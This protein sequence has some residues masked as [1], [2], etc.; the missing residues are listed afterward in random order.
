MTEQN[1]TDDTTKPTNDEDEGLVLDVDETR[2]PVK[3]ELH[4]SGKESI[5]PTVDTWLHDNIRYFAERRNQKMSQGV[6]VSECLLFDP[7][8]SVEDGLTALEQTIDGQLEQHGVDTSQ[9]NE[10]FVQSLAET[11]IDMYEAGTSHGEYEEG[12][13]RAKLWIP[14]VVKESAS[15]AQNWSEHI[16]QSLIY[17]Y[18]CAFSDRL[19]RLACKRDVFEYYENGIEPDHPVAKDIVRDEMDEYV[20]SPSVVETVMVTNIKDYLDYC[21]DID[22]WE[23]RREKW[24]ELYTHVGGTLS[25]EFL[26]RN[27]ARAHGIGYDYAEGEV[28]KWAE[29]CEVLKYAPIEEHE[30]TSENFVEK[31]EELDVPEHDE[32]QQAELVDRLFATLEEQGESKVSLGD[33]ATALYEA[34][35][36]RSDNRKTAGKMLMT[37]DEVAGLDHYK[38]ME[39]GVVYLSLHTVSE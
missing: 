13:R 11:E 1:P 3:T 38:Y 36:I 35:F 17:T 4:G 33:V 28:D 14:P 10:L 24:D 9:L 25:V 31:K 30:V 29:D 16:E 32:E 18:A 39:T 26:A 34:G 6:L 23:T 8:N 2:T 19:D 27:V 5:R 7:N 37:Y 12:T 21:D 20:G 15:W 22:D